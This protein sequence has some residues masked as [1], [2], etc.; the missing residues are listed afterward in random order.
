MLELECGRPCRT[1]GM[2]TVTSPARPPRR[3]HMLE[4]LTRH[5][6]TSSAT[7][8]AAAAAAAGTAPF[9]P[10]PLLAG[11]IVLPLYQ[12]SSRLLN[13]ARVTEPELYNHQQHGAPYRLGERVSTVVN[14]HNPSIEA[15]ILPH[16][17]G[18]GAAIVVVP[19]GGHRVLVIGSEGADCVPFFANYGISVV[20][21]RERLR[22]D[23][24]NMTT[25]AMHDTF[26]ALRLVRAH[27]TEWGLD[28]SK[29]GILGFS[30]GAE[31][32]AGSA[33]EYPLIE[34]GVRRERGGGGEVLDE[35][36]GRPDF[37]SLVYPGPSPFQ[38]PQLRLL[39]GGASR[40][41]GGGATADEMPPPPPPIPA[42]VPPSFITTPVDGARCH[43]IWATEYF[44]AMLHADVPNLEF[45]VYGTGTHGGGL[46]HRRGIPFGGWMA[47][48]I[49]WLTDLGFLDGVGVPTKAARDVAAFARGEAR[50]GGLAQ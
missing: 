6:V 33:V 45:H 43:S 34:E 20:I 18:T 31:L 49:D 22:V 2:T 19:G 17:G 11:G 26:Q 21:L 14:V 39:A 42:D 38:S 36:S 40:L 4:A 16:G 25:D 9:V 8:A 13:S 15:H 28:G 12:P 41:N 47:R 5:V 32:A 10:Q 30:A 24:Y 7:T 37:V 1:S 46:S 50:P 48:F 23:G 44:T 27:A 3:R 29:I 35:V